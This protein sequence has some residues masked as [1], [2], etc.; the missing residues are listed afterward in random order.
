[1]RRDR[2]QNRVSGSVFTLPTCAVLFLVSWYFNNSSMLMEPCTWGT[3]VVLMLTAYVL[4]EMNNRNQ[5]LRVRSRM[6]SSVWLILAAS[7]PL[8]QTFGEG[9]IA[10]TAMVVAYFMLFRTYQKT[11]CEAD[12]FHY[13]LMLGVGSLFLPQLICCLPLFLWHQMVFLRSMTFRTLC[14]AI[15]GCIFPYLVVGGYMLLTDDFSYLIEWWQYI[16]IWQPISQEAYKQLSVTQIADWVLVSFLSM[17]GLLHYLSSSYNDKIQ[18]RMFLYIL[19]MQ[20]FVLELFVCLQPRHLD[21]YMPLFAVT[22]APLIAHY[23]ALT[24]SWISNLVFILSILSCM[25]LVCLHTM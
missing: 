18:V 8:L 22:G 15:V 5:L 2:L 20:W 9:Q 17:L 25:A 19:C 7:I 16:H 6:V 10:A 12:S 11:G 14:A 3:F 24:H 13:A 1:M 4:V 23:F 21:D